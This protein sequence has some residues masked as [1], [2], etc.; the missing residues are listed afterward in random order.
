MKL[1]RLLSALGLSA[2][3]ASA[4]AAPQPGLAPLAAGKGIEAAG[5][6][7]LVRD[8]VVVAFEARPLEGKE[9]MEGHLA[10]VRFSI[11]DE[12]TGKPV[13]GGRPGAWMDIGAN[14]QGKAGSEQKECK[15]KIGLYLK[16]AVGIRPLVDLNG[17]FLLVMNRDA[18]VTVIDPMVSM[19]GRTSTL[20]SV[21]LKSPPMDWVNVGE[22]KQLF[23]TLP[24]ANAVAVVDTEGFKVLK[25]IEVG[26]QPTRIVRQPDG[27]YLWV[28]NNAREAEESGV[29]VIDAKDMKVVMKAATGRGH[30][31]IAISSDNR[32]AFVTNREDGTVTVFDVGTL[33]KLKDIKTGSMPLSVAYSKLSGA[34]YVSDGKDGTVTVI[35][36]GKLEVMKTMVTKPGLGPLRFTPDDRFALVVNTA[37]SV[38]H[39]IDPGTNEIIQSPK[40]QTQ[41]F[42]VVFTRGYAYV[43]SLGSER[44]SMINL[45]SLGA[46][47]EAIVQ[48][49][50]AGSYPPKSGGDL[51]LADAV[52]PALGEMGV[53]AVSPA[54][55]AT[56]FY[57]EGM[58]APMSSYPSRG[59]FAR[60][61]TVVDRSLREVEPGVFVGRFR[62]PAP[63][64]FDVAFSLDQ[65]RLVHCFTADAKIN[66]EMEKLRNTTAVEFLPQERVFKETETAKVRFRVI[67]GTGDPKARLR[68]VL[69][70]YFLVPASAP[71]DAIAVEVAEGVYEASVEMPEAGVYY[72]YVS[73][74]SL[75]LGYN[76]SGFLSVMAKEIPAASGAPAQSAPAQPALPKVKQGREK[77]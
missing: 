5:P 76:D 68:D 65:P 3:C 38:V 41:P 26:K 67:E 57:M 75:R 1:K 51:P 63:G 25:N 30:H 37:E 36:A 53:F 20:A 24:A 74:P 71:R 46:G 47:K 27:K 45:I 56:Y 12:R 32:L 72:V 4:I 40:V 70:R 6:N 69:V 9:L 43:R 11:T 15:E 48:S 23:V 10:E 14:I 77:G 62:L 31:E 17:Y 55:N 7:R 22:F 50:A 60:A 16:G 8:G 42:Q 28:G 29:T 73:V 59:K 34:A 39:V 66:P 54:D 13:A 19:G 35:D 64:H 49:F 33:K 2:I 18:S 44:V 21:V 61:V 52:A 58:N